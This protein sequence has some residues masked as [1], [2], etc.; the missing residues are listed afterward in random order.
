MVCQPWVS[1][2]SSP[3]TTNCCYETGQSCSKTAECCGGLACAGGKC[4]CEAQGQFC[5]RD[6]DCCGGGR[7]GGRHLGHVA[8]RGGRGWRAFRR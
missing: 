6:V 8:R 5:V 3:V 4:A 1:S 7:H 2:T